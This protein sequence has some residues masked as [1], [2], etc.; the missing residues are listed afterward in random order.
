MTYQSTTIDKTIPNINQSMFLPAIQREFV[1]EEEQIVRLF[2]SIAR[3]YP[4]G[5]F[6]YWDVRGKFAENQVKYRF[7]K[8]YITEGNHPDQFDDLHHRNVKIR[9]EYVDL[10]DNLSLV[11]DG[12]QRLTSFYIGLVGSLTDRGHG[13]QRKKPESWTRKQLYLNLLSDPRSETDDALQ[14]KYKFE[15]KTDT[16]ISD[17]EYWFLVGDI[18]DMDEDDK[19]EKVDEVLHELEISGVDTSDASR[20]HIRQN[21]D[22]LW[23]CI[24]ERKT[25]NY[26]LINDENPDKILDV[27]IR[28]NEGGTQLG[29]D[30]ILLSMSTAHW[31]ETKPYVDARQEI[32]SFVDQ[33]NAYQDI[34]GFDFDISFVLKNLLSMSDLQID[35]DI[36]N[37]MDESNL[38]K[39]KDTWRENEFKQAL[40][41]TLDLVDSFGFDGHAVASNISL[42][43]IGY[44]FYKNP[45][46]ELSWGSN[47]GQQTRKQLFYWLCASLLKSVYASGTYAKVGGF[48]EEIRAAPA[49][50]FPMKDL[51]ERLYRYNE[52]L[53]FTEDEIRE[54][55]K[56]LKSTNKR[57]LIFLSLLYYPEPASQHTKFQMDHIFPRSE[58]SRSNL[59][60]NHGFDLERAERYEKLRDNVNNLQLLTPSANSKKSDEPFDDWLETRNKEYYQKHLIPENPD[61]H[62]VERFEDFISKREDLIVKRVREMSS[63]IESVLESE[64]EENVDEAVG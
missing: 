44:F 46:I 58:L 7:I 4:I 24:R 15:F 41:R 62:S 12:Q 64:I 56:K 38:E 42:M 40:F 45:S 25:V 20:K 2:D 51:S 29:K 14:M 59:V 49:E 53:A 31:S 27:F 16:Q 60:D 28:A 33:L 9:D 18:L 19:Y 47:H 3:G 61:L 1:W 30:E 13:K 11:L 48:R 57:S 37:F 5:S 36:Q 43:P 63:E 55:I 35:Y 32:T 23:N 22:A 52:T 6:L 8:D 26:Y 50:E 10:P 34:S 17:E 39:M 21:I 54:T